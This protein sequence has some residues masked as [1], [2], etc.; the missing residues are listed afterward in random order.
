MNENQMTEEEL[1]SADQAFWDFIED[2][3][4]ELEVTADYFIYEFLL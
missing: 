3:S 1:M 2:Q 4:A